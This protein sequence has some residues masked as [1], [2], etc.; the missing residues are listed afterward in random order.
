MGESRRFEVT[1]AYAVVV[2]EPAAVH[3]A[4]YARWCSRLTEVETFTDWHR[5]QWQRWVDDGTA[6]PVGDPDWGTDRRGVDVALMEFIGPDHRLANDI[7]GAV[8]HYGGSRCQPDDLPWPPPRA[9]Q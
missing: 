9:A 2:S 4:A 1:V 5:E 6:D 8:A 7:P 3:E